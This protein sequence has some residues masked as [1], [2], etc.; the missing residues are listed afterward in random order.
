MAAALSGRNFTFCPRSFTLEETL[1]APGDLATLRSRLPARLNPAGAHSADAVWFL[2]ATEDAWPDERR[3]SSAASTLKCSAKQTCRTR[4]RSRDGSL[5][6][7]AIHCAPARLCS[8]SSLQLRKT[9]RRRR[10]PS[11]A[12]HRLNLP[13]RRSRMP[14]GTNCRAQAKIVRLRS[15]LKTSAAFPFRRAK[16]AAAPACLLSSRNV[17]SR[18]S[19][20]HASARAAG[21]R[22]RQGS[23]LSSAASSF[24]TYFTLFGLG[25]R[26]AFAPTAKLHGARLTGAPGSAGHVRRVLSR[27]RNAPR[28]NLAGSVMPA[29]YLELERLRLTR[30]VCRVA[31]IRIR[32]GS[33]PR[34]SRL[35]PIRTITL[36]WSHLRSAPRPA[37][38]ASTTARMLVIDYKS[39]D[40]SPK[41][42]ELPR[43]DD[44][45]LTLYAGFALDAGPETRRPRLRQ[46]SAR[47]A[48]RSPAASARLASTLFAGLQNGSALAKNALT[49]EHALRLA[50][51]HRTARQ[52]LPLMAGPKSIRANI[53]RPAS[54]AGCRRFVAFRSNRAHRTPKAKTQTAPTSWR[55]TVSRHAAWPK[56]PPPDQLQRELALDPTRSILVQAPAG[57][58]KTDLLTRRFLRLLRRRLTIRDRLSRS[59]SPLPRQLRRM[60]HRILAELEKATARSSKSSSQFAERRR[61]LNAVPCTT[62]P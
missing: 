21:N 15:P 19:R 17:R 24:T 53:P 8:R 36:E 51:I 7:A 18:H 32:P 42:W 3:N 57:S 1:F 54:A 37:S 61:V 27:N 58:G 34:S 6:Q 43:P 59:P 25:R 47:R 12:P 56:S 33:L 48:R 39:G 10:I 28:L 26:T 14:R 44:V 9:N 23:H 2:G 52:R 22:P 13:F 4:L 50:R 46:A 16:F 55:R 29:R 38:T 41:S 30:L 60:R 40:V 31:R 49:A 11:L 35:K 20:T 62:R 45:Q 5:A